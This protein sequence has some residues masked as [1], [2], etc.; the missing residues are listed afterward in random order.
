MLDLKLFM[1]PA[2]E[3]KLK[4]ILNTVTDG[5]SFAQGIIDYQ[6]KELQQSSLNLKLD[7]DEFEK[8]YQ[9]SSE[10]FYEQFSQ[11]KLGDETDFIIW[12]G[13]VEMLRYNQAQLLMLK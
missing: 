5:E 6:I 10:L 2:T 9:M 13:L 11:G 8:K 1:Q 7:L 3:Q 4:K 12:S